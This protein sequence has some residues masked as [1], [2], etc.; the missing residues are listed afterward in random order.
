MLTE[1]HNSCKL[2]VK[3]NRKLSSQNVLFLSSSFINRQ[4]STTSLD[5]LVILF[6][7]LLFTV[8]QRNAYHVMCMV[9]KNTK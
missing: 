6:E 8:A 5:K 3:P 2:F 4:R 1:Q 9:K 7:L